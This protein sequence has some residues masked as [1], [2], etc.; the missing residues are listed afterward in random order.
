[1]RTGVDIKPGANPHRATSDRHRDHRVE[2]RTPFGGL[3]RFRL[4]DL[5]AL[6]VDPL[7]EVPHTAHQGHKDHRQGEFG[8]GA[9]G[10]AGPD[11]EPTRIGPHFGP[12][13]TLHQ[14]VGNAR[15]VNE[16]TDYGH[17][18]TITTSITI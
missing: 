18:Q 13:R 3:P 1:M 12:D 2:R 5:P 8:A 17:F 11:A 4:L 16:R 15:S 14:E 7:V 10:V 9:R 6:A